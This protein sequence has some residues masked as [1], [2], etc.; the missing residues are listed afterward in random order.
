LTGYQLTS[1][2][3]NGHLSYFHLALKI[4]FFIV[5]ITST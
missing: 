3:S 5:V 1:V 2:Q 4:K